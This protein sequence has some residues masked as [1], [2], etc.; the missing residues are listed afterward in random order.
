MKAFKVLAVALLTSL[1]PG[2]VSSVN[3]L[4]TEND[5]IFNQQLLGDWSDGETKLTFTRE[6]ENAYIL[7]TSNEGDEIGYETHLV[8]LDHNTFLDIYPSDYLKSSF[9]YEAT[10]FPVHYFWK[11]EI[12]QEEIVI[13]TISS[14]WADSLMNN[15]PPDIPYVESDDGSIL[16][17]GSTEELQKF[18]KENENLFTDPVVYRKVK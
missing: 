6:G 8:K 12:A 13:S 3:P 1:F 16:L 5:L 18:F 4:F 11:I 15:K 9:L 17:T 7:I 2:C 10:H 14:E